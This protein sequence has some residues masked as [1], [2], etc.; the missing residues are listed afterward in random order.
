LIGTAIWAGG[1][2]PAELPADQIFPRFIVD[3]LPSGLSGLLIAAILAATMGTHS[4]AISALASSM[5]HD[6]YSSYTGVRD[7]ER[8]LRVGR[9][10]SLL[11]GAL[12]TVAALGFHS[13]A[14]GGQTPVVIFAL[15]IASITY[16]A[17]LGAYLLA[18]RWSRAVG[19]DVLGAIAVGLSIM[20]VVF[21]S[22]QLSAIPALA[23]TAPA[24][25]LAWPWYVP[26]G[27]LLT[28]GTGVL[29][30]FLPRAT[31]EAA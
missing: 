6:L 10:M 20:L 12:V 23:W 25:R 28:F 1:F 27:T 19:R 31:R 30:S 15:S 22:K 26:L 9:A 16:G 14:G 11:W 3:H 18:G 5:T 17:L 21:F 24:G 2:T 8:L 7:P 13:L 29:L 4:S